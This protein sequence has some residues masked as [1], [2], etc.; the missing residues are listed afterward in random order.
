M[1]LIITYQIVP[2]GFMLHCFMLLPC[3][4]ELF[5]EQEFDLRV[6]Q[7]RIVL[8]LMLQPP[9]I[10]QKGLLSPVEEVVEL[11]LC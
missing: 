5:V 6:G 3:P 2:D 4:H 7:P 11:V 1:N 8:C 9:D 10:L